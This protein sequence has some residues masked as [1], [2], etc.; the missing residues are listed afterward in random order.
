MGLH[1]GGRMTPTTKVPRS[2]LVLSLLAIAGCGGGGFATDPG[3][4]VLVGD[5][6]AFAVVSSGGGFGPSVPV[7]GAPCAVGIWT[8]TVRVPT[9][10]L[11]WDRCDVAG[12]AADPASYTHATGSRVLSATELD[13]ARSAARQVHVSDRMTCGADK[14]TY[15]MSVTTPAGTMVY[16]DDFYSCQRTDQTFVKSEELDSLSAELQRLGQ[17]R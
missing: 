12:D 1:K 15:T 9:S 17:A 16:A 13:A 7:Q 14:P 6:T 10:E 3:E 5:A 4:S 2:F 8:Y 11:A